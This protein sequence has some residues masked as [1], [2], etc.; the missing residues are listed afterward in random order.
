VFVL[1]EN[2]AELEVEEDGEARREGMYNVISPIDT[3][4]TWRHGLAERHEPGTGTTAAA[5][6][7]RRDG[8]GR[9]L[10]ILPSPRVASSIRTDGPCGDLTRSAPPTTTRALAAGPVLALPELL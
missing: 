8:L 10:E 3:P 9:V 7:P 5:R 6:R 2:A 4:E 1:A